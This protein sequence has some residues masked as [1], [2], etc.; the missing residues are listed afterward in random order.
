MDR[1]AIALTLALLLYASSG[2]ARG[3][4]VLGLCGGASGG[5]CSTSPYIVNETGG[6]AA[7]IGYDSTSSGYAVGLLNES[8][9][10]LKICALELYVRE[11][12]SLSGKTLYLEHWST[13]S[14]NLS[15]KIADVMS[16]N[17]TL[18]PN[19][20]GWYK[21]TLPAEIT[22]N[23]N[24]ALVFTLNEVTGTSNYITVAIKS[25]GSVINDQAMIGFSS[26]GL[27]YYASGAVDFMTKIYRV[28]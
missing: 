8:S 4:G 13:A 20:I 11:D 3:L 23:Q 10:A 9:T 14:Y 17:A 1:R 16:I 15:T 2:W 18:L 26:A 22:L 21:I 28:E 25:G 5:E 27:G 19:P 6:T 7:R 24:D 12:G